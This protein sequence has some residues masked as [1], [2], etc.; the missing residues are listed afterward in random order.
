MYMFE[1]FLVLIRKYNFSYMFIY[2]FTIIFMGV[3][4]KLELLT[5]LEEELLK[6]LGFWKGR[7]SEFLKLFS[8]GVM[9]NH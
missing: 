1:T 2:V 5:F 8:K 6:S 7:R 4:C 9:I 3:R